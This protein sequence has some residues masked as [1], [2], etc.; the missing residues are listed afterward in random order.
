MYHRLIYVVNYVDM[1]LE[2]FFCIIA[3]LYFYCCTLEIL[4]CE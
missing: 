4:L 1:Y 2:I 3:M